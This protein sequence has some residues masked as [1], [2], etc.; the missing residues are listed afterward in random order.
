MSEKLKKI[1]PEKKTFKGS[2]VYD[3]TQVEVVAFN[4]ESGPHPHDVELT[5]KFLVR[6]PDGEFFLQEESRWE[7]FVEASSEHEEIA[8]G[9]LYVYRLTPEKAKEHFAAFQERWVDA[10]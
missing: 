6:M 8:P 1:F 2:Y 4:L 7:T 10:I 3:S 9:T 5:S